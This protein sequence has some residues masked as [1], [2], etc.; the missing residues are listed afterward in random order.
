MLPAAQNGARLAGMSKL[1]PWRGV[2]LATLT[3]GLDPDSE[4]HRVSIPT[5]WGEV[6]ASGLAA[7]AGDATPQPWGKL[8]LPAAAERWI[9]PL[10][11][12]Q[13][14]LGD[15]LHGMLLR[16]EGCPDRA[17]WRGEPGEA[18]FVLHLAAFAEP[19]AGFDADGFDAG[20]LAAACALHLRGG[21][22][23]RLAGLDGVLAALGIDYDSE[24]ARALA[25]DLVRR[26]RAKI[27]RVDPA[28]R[29]AADIAGPAEALLGVETS[30]IAP[31]F[32]HVDAGGHLTV[33]AEARL[34]Q[35]RL[36]PE[37]ALALTLEGR[38][39]LRTASHTAHLAMHEALAR[40][41]DRAPPQPALRR[42]ALAAATASRASRRRLPARARG[43]TQKVAIGGHRVFL[44]T[45]EYEDGAVGEVS[46]ALGGREGSLARGL[47]EA[48]GTAMSIAL[49]HGV[50]LDAFVDAFAHTR[51]GMAGHVEGDPA[52]A[53]ASSP[54]DYAVRAL[55]EAYGGR[56]IADPETAIDLPDA[57]AELPLGLPSR[58]KTLRL[59][60]AS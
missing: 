20:L 11:A 12:A 52:I 15:L 5:G 3:V 23:I 29:L 22:A 6:A 30:G 38:P 58:P 44:Q 42:P 7:L 9:A 50:P 49:Q 59:V 48:V 36:S 53:A 60:R 13:P 55:A 25:V 56:R 17:I 10:D 1:L 14:G 19:A 37:R 8:T 40:L 39:P 21:G 24:E 51:F 54:L 46:L 31:A 57:S 2:R 41:L 26:A 18:G 27:R 43:Y 32:S 33:A 4:T 34:A 45:A 16:R 28:I 47:A 35:L